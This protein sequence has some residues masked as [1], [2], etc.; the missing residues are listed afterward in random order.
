M[1]KGNPFGEVAVRSAQSASVEIQANREVSEVQAQVLLAKKFPRDPKVSMDRILNECHRPTLAEHA[2]YTYK[3]GGSEVSG[4]TIRLAEC[5]ERAWGN[6]VSGWKVLER[7]PGETFMMAYA[8]DLETNAM[9]RV[10][11]VVPHKRTTK[12]GSYEISDERDLYELEANMAAR[13]K[14]SC[15]LA[16]IP[17]DVVDI[18]VEECQKTLA[19]NV[20][21]IKKARETMMTAFTAFGVTKEMIEKRFQRR[22]EY[23]GPGEIVALRSIFNALKQGGATVE[24]FFELP[25][26]PEDLIGEA[27]NTGKEPGQSEKGF[28]LE[29]EQAELSAEDVI[30]ALMDYRETEIPQA[31]RDELEKALDT[32]ERD[33]KTLTA[34]LEKVKAA[35]ARNTQ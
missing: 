4:P 2:M 14:R 29:P 15:I 3:R 26:K 22:L 25:K 19:A 1:E 6:I 11:F 12:K 20:G 31:C 10:D 9:H 16:L 30:S 5:I 35:L 23:I 33:I 18:A 34:L 13:R 27:L 7:K 28:N 21:D 8:W 24:D 32:N 17:G